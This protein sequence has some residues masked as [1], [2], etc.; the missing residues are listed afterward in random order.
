MRLPAHGRHRVLVFREHDQEVA[1]EA[2]LEDDVPL[3]RVALE[4]FSSG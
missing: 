1:A 3:A 4:A 2:D